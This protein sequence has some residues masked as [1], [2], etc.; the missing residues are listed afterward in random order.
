MVFIVQ[1][2][3][4]SLLLYPLEFDFDGIGSVHAFEFDN[5]GIAPL[6]REAAAELEHNDIRE[7]IMVEKA[8]HPA[9]VVTAEFDLLP[10][11]MSGV[12][13]AFHALD[14][15]DDP[16]SEPWFSSH[17]IFLLSS[18]DISGSKQG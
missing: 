13:L 8:A 17:D 6:D 9:R 5:V 12:A 14:R 2:Y 10:N 7:D 4:V 3:W 15:S 16:K 1:R 11:L 18:N